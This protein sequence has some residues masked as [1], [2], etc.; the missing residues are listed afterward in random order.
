MDLG[1][2]LDAGHAEDASYSDVQQFFDDSLGFL[3]LDR[4]FDFIHFEAQV[5]QD[6]L[7]IDE[8]ISSL[9]KQPPAEIDPEHGKRVRDLLFRDFDALLHLALLIKASMSIFSSPTLTLASIRSA[10]S[11]PS[12][13]A[14]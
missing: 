14:F 1:M 4:L 10:R 11:F 2:R 3:D 13:F 12:G 9:F 7:G 8:G 5:A 6:L